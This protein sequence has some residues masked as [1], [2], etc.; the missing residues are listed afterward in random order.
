MSKVPDAGMKCEGRYEFHFAKN[1]HVATF[2]IEIA[3]DNLSTSG[4]SVPALETCKKVL[5]LSTGG[6]KK[7]GPR[8]HGPALVFGT[9]FASPL[10]GRSKASH[11]NDQLLVFA[12]RFRS[13]GSRKRLRKRIDLGV[14][15]TN[16]SVSI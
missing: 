4:Y 8:C 2:Q 16:S 1:T 5:R 9:V 10:G 3:A 15:S 7:P 12:A 6:N 11:L 13:C 14:T